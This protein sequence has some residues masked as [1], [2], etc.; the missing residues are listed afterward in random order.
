[1]STSKKHKPLKQLTSPS[2]LLL[3]KP[4]TQLFAGLTTLHSRG[5]RQ[6][7]SMWL[8]I[9][10]FHSKF[11]LPVPLRPTRLGK[12]LRK[13]R[14]KFLQEEFDE[15]KSAL[16]KGDMEQQLDALV[17]LVYVA[18]G[19]AVMS[20]FDFEE[21]WRRVHRAN[22]LKVKPRKG[23]YTKRRSAFDIIKP[24]GWQAPDLSDLAS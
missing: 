18:L 7:V 4:W 1:M 8:D 17:D 22:M 20:G 19:T 15:Y 11:Q 3:S 24:P 12:A 9:L 14:V 2:G 21:A 16:R 13:F 6:P 23:Q 10:E 5:A